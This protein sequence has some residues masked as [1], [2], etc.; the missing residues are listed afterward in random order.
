MQ[1]EPD[2]LLWEIFFNSGS[3]KDYLIYKAEETTNDNT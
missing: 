2:I 1:P 3:V